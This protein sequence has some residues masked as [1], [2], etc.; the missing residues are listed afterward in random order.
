MKERLE[1]G[2]VNCMVYALDVVAVDCLLAHDVVVVEGSLYM[3]L[4]SG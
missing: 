3:A 2:G 1:E 4:K